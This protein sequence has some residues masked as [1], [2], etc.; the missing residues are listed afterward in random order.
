MTDGMAIFCCIYRTLET[1]C[2]DNPLKCESLLTN[3]LVNYVPYM[4]PQRGRGVMSSV[5]RG[6]RRFEGL[7]NMPHGVYYLLMWHNE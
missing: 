3:P 5:P 7:D 1:A 2:Y 6:L 4:L